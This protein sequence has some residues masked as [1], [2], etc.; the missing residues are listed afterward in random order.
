MRWYVLGMLRHEMEFATV[1]TF[2]ATQYDSKST[3]RVLQF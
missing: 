1:A 2:P 3:G